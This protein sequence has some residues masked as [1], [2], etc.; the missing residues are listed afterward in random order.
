MSDGRVKGLNYEGTSVVHRRIDCGHVEG[1][2]C[3]ETTN[4]FLFLL[5][6][7]FLGE[8]TNVYQ[9]KIV[10]NVTQSGMYNILKKKKGNV[11]SFFSQIWYK[12]VSLYIFIIYEF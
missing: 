12:T 3:G 8:T 4:V 7:F 2:E 1:A 5:F 11:K 10:N 9:K 6:L